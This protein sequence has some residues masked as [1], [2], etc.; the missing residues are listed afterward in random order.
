ML[1]QTIIELASERVNVEHHMGH[2][3]TPA[4]ALANSACCVGHFNV[5]RWP[6]QRA[7]FA[8]F[9]CRVEKL[10][11]ESLAER[12]KMCNFVAVI[13]RLTQIMRKS[14]F[15]AVVLIAGLQT[16]WAQKM[17]VRMNND[18][19]YVY[20]VPQVAEVTFSEDLVNKEYVN[21]GLPSGTLWATCNVGADRPEEFGDYFAWG[22]VLPKD[23]YD[24]FTYMFCN[25][26]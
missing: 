3:K 6:T 22:E 1:L 12:N 14:V 7:A 13:T 11:L 23:R 16:T 26:T 24:W 5:P 4:A 17:T 2:R 15:A 10:I 9:I 18:K 21:L 19:T 8:R 25:D 20:K